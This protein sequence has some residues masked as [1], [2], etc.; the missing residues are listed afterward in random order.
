MY[1]IK[2]GRLKWSLR[3][4]YVWFKFINYIYIILHGCNINPIILSTVK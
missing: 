2:S 3:A 4:E 1:Y